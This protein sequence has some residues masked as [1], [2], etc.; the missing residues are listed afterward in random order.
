MSA[1][2]LGNAASLYIQY[3]VYYG[4]LLQNVSVQLV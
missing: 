1:V 4:F 3:C 2:G